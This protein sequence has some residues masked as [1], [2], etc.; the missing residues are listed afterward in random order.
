MTADPATTTVRVRLGYPVPAGAASITVVGLDPP[1]VC[2]GID[3]PGGPQTTAWYA[4]G[5]VLTAGGVRWR[6][7][8]TS[9]PP[10]LAPD[11]PPG[12]AGDHTV[13]ILERLEGSVDG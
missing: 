4:S 2:L 8:R 13:A 5:N 9:P 10:R 3:E 1:L 7:V 12:T 11:A 6:I